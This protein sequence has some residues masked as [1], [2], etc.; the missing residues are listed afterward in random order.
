MKFTSTIIAL[1]AVLAMVQAQTAGPLNAASVSIPP[2]ITL[3]LKRRGGLGD[4]AVGPLGA[5]PLGNALKGTQAETGKLLESAGV[6]ALRK[7]GH[8]GK[9]NVNVD[10]NA[11]IDLTI[12]AIVKA[13][14]D[15]KVNLKA[16][17]AAKVLAKLDVKADAKL[18]AK[19]DGKA[20]LFILIDQLFIRPKLLSATGWLFVPISDINTSAHPFFVFE[21]HTSKHNK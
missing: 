14:A 15:V 2:G 1:S 21:Y 10:V 6:P 4:T 19:I 12:K 5:T 8:K 3:P 9:G 16:K 20:C 18:R 7:R 11:K 13:I 17:V